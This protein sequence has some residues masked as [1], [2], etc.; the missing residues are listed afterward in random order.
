MKFWTVRKQW[1]GH[2]SIASTESIIYRKIGNNVLRVNNVQMS[3]TTVN[4]GVVGSSPTGGARTAPP[5]GGGAV[6]F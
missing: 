2:A 3:L 6:S 1:T 5:H 4:R